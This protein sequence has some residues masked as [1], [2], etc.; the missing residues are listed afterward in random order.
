MSL[1]IF[2]IYDDI[3]TLTASQVYTCIFLCFEYLF[4]S[5]IV[6]ID[7]HNPHEQQQFEVLSN[8]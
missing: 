5:N 6:N 2:Q 1:N 7:K 4:I 3:I 8:F